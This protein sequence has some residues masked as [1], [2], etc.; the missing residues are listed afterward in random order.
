[1][2]TKNENENKI[3]TKNVQNEKKEEE[4]THGVDI[5]SWRDEK[6]NILFS[7]WDFAGHEEYHV[8]HSFFFS[9]GSVYLLLFDC[10]IEINELISKNKLLYWF[11]FIQ[12]QI[13]IN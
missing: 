6:T 3:A 5:F 13:G 11:H 12:S 4:M 2:G 10:S 7:V 9:S 8:A 1:M